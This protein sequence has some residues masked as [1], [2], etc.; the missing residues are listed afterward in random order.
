MKN[1]FFYVFVFCIFVIGIFNSCSSSTAY[2]PPLS[3]DFEI[4]DFTYTV[5]QGYKVYDLNGTV[6]ANYL[7]NTNSE[8]IANG[9]LFWGDGKS[10]HFTGM[11]I[12][13][14]PAATGQWKSWNIWHEYA[15]IGTYSVDITVEAFFNNGKI[16]STFKKDVVI[17]K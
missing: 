1:I 12:P 17:S 2:T 10:S 6:Y 14:G 15:N 4:T 11:P 13:S 16:T 9:W 7:N 5:S 8:V 3:N